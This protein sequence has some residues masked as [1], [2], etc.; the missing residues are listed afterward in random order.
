[1]QLLSQKFHSETDLNSPN[2]SSG[3]FRTRNPSDK[4]AMDEYG[5]AHLIYTLPTL[6]QKYHPNTI[7]RE[8]EN[9]SFEG[10]DT[11]ALF[12]LEEFISSN[13]SHPV[14]L[15]EHA[16]GDRDP[17]LRELNKHTQEFN[18]HF[19]NVAWDKV[20]EALGKIA[21]QAEGNDA[22]AYQRLVDYARALQGL[23]QKHLPQL[24]AMQESKEEVSA[25][26]QAHYAPNFEMPDFETPDLPPDFPTDNSPSR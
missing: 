17:L 16:I 26:R 3:D 18:D 2:Y 9:L 19:E 24:Q 7:K 10:N 8:I 20:S 21:A 23:I 5:N 15:A 22:P 4:N 13:I 11:K 25:A 12:K 1:M 14:S 6:L